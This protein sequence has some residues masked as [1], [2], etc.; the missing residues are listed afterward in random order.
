MSG[1]SDTFAIGVTG[2]RLHRLAGCDLMLLEHRIASLFQAIDA[3]AKAN[4]KSELALLTNFADGADRIAGW[5]ALDLGWRLDAILPFPRDD[6]ARDFEN[7]AELTAFFAQLERARS[8]SY[9]QPARAQ[10]DDGTEG[11]ERAGRAILDRCDMLF[12]VWDKAPARGRGGAAQIIAEAIDREIPVV[13]IDPREAIPI[14]AI[15]PSGT[16][17]AQILRTAVASL[18]SS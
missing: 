11:Y 17:T 1:L 8:Q 10:G 18:T 16:G 14:E 7:A 9:L 15:C 3:S 13:V 2:H 4:G 12:A 6:F 5:A